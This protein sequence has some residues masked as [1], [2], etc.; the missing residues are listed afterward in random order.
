MIFDTL[1]S[2]QDYNRLTVV[3]H[4]IEKFPIVLPV[5]P[6]FSAESK[7]PFGFQ[8]KEIEKT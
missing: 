2:L 5:F 7:L 3:S 8:K 1:L 4:R 6:S